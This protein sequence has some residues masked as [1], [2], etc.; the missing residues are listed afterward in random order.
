[1]SPGDATRPSETISVTTATSSAPA[2]CAAAAIGARSCRWPNTSGVCTTTQ[3]TVSSIAPAR[4][5]LPP[6]R[7]RK[8]LDLLVSE[9]RHGRDRVAIVRMKVAGDHRL[10]PPGDA[11]RHQHRLGGGGR[12]V[13]HGGVGDFQAGEHRHLGLELEQILQRALGDL[14]L[15]GRV[16]GEELGALDQ[17]I[18]RRRQVVPVG[19]AA[20]EERHCARCD[21]LARHAAQAAARPRSRPRG[22]AGWAARAAAGRPARRQTGRRCVQRRCAPASRR[23]PPR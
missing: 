8:D 1:M 10:A 12:A 7:G 14:R 22:A 19:A 18:D 4:L 9:A 17:V 20:D 3:E 13:V 5:S 16:R 21:V 15:V 6:G 2:A 23:G 11:M